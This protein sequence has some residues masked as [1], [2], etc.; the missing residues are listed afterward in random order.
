MRSTYNVETV[1]NGRSVVER[2]EEVLFNGKDHKLLE[3]LV[4]HH[5][6]LGGSRDVSVVVEDS[7]TSI[8]GDMDLHGDV[9]LEVSVDLSLLGG[10]HS[11][12]ESSH[13]V[14]EALVSDFVN[15]L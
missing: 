12:V 11:G 1:L 10:M 4:P 6:L 15:H 3:N 14:V 9:P 7:H 5:E 2:S 8:S 13:C